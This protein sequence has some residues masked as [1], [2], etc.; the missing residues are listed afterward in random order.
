LGPRGRC[1]AGRSPGF[2]P[3]NDCEVSHV[4]NSE[5]NSH[6]CRVAVVLETTDLQTFT[7]ASGYSSQVMS[8]PVR[9]TT[10]NPTY[11]SEFDE[12]YAG[13]GSVVQD[14]TRPA[15]NLIMIYEAEN[16]CPG[17]VWQQPFYATVGFARSSD[18][19]Q[20]ATSSTSELHFLAINLLHNFTVTARESPDR[21]R[22]PRS[23]TGVRSVG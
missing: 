18:N 16:H 7:F 10:C 8:V 23:D 11:D 17:G 5:F 2:G 12:N 15:G 4:C 14:P 13:P 22:A 3:I 9:F 1:D 20:P 6:H 19:D 21:C